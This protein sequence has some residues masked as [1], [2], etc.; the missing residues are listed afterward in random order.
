MSLRPG[1]FLLKLR[2]SAVVFIHDLCMIPLA[3]LGGYWLRFNLGE[4]P[5]YIFPI[6]L[7]V[8]PIVIG[9]QALAFYWF[10]MYRGVW[11]F[12]SLPDLIRIIKAVVVGTALIIGILSL[13]YRLENIP[14]S[15]A[16][17]YPL[18]LLIL[19][20]GP[21]FLY[22]WSKDSKLMLATGKRV[23]IVGAGRAGEMLVRDMLRS[24]N[25]YSRAWQILYAIYCV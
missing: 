7:Q 19:L 23:L 18:V 1:Y 20:S 16:L 6:A 9:I 5:D 10:G 24:T 17:L 22:R 13:L 3:W 15:I 4:I 11:R 2:R 25:G 21:R 8:L 12:A 14:R